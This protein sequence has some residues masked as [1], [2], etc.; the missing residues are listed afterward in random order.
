MFYLFTP[1]R[2]KTIQPVFLSGHADTWYFK[3][4][5]TCDLVTLEK[6]R[7]LNTSITIDSFPHT[8]PQ[9]LIF[10]KW[11][12]ISWIFNSGKNYAKNDDAQRLPW[13]RILNQTVD[14]YMKI[15][16]LPEVVLK[17]DSDR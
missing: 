5:V 13:K 3:L 10:Q 14:T 12:T 9:T 6:N 15:L 8:I 7:T 2:D 11:F 1:G 17:S 16:E 4:I